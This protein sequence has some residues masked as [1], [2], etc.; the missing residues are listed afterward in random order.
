MKEKKNSLALTLAL[1]CALGALAL[2][3]LCFVS[4]PEDQSHLIDDLY[5]KNARL[6]DR[7]EELEG[8][9]DQLMTAVSL[10][11]WKLD[12]AAWPDSTGADVT[13]SAVPS[14]Y[15]PDFR[16]E[17]IVML[18]G[19][20]VLRQQCQW[21][22][23]AFVATVSLDAADGY[24]YYCDLTTPAGSRKL[25][26][27]GPDSADAGAVVY[28]GSSLSAYCNLVVNDW[29]DDSGES[30]TLTDAYAQVQLPRISAQGTV[31]IDTAEIVLRL[32]GAESAR[33]PIRLAPSE[34][35]GSLELVITDLELP[36]PELK[37]GDVLELFL[38]VTLTDGRHLNAFGVTWRMEDDRIS[39]AVG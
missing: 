17:F 15:Q 31:E 16:A 24:S 4:I 27:T 25:P 30:L 10:Q 21:D 11:S 1:V 14:V 22:G 33:I 32:N 29:T 36:M 20:Q 3:A 38:E 8:K 23:G 7:V 34:V 5:E 18:D 39:S 19:E 35:V 13:L 2:S 28:L 12:V 6:Q 26:L 9:L 37:E